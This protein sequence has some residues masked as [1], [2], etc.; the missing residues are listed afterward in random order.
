MNV[1]ELELREGWNDDTPPM[2]TQ[3]AFPL[4]AEAGTKASAVVYF[5]IAPGDHLGRHT[6]SAEEIL[7]VAEGTGEAVV[8]AERVALEAGSLAV[9]PELVPHAV[10]NTGES[11]L[12]VVGF[13]AAAEVEHIFDR[14]VHPMGA[15]V[16]HTP[17]A[18]VPA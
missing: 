6:D 10:H 13:F 7:Y 5:E 14:P 2:R 15:T 11:T 16:M 12:K 9:V 18:E 4:H 17:M 8:G 3:V 1:N